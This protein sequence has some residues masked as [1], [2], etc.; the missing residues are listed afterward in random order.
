MQEDSQAVGSG[1]GLDGGH[2]SQ[3]GSP[4]SE[5]QDGRPDMCVVGL[6]VTDRGL[7]ESPLVLRI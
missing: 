2:W 3:T 5:N 7:C 6:S 1:N 4:L